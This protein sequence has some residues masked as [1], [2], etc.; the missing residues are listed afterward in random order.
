MYTSGNGFFPF[1]N[2]FTAVSEELQPSSW[3]SGQ[4]EWQVHH[5]TQPWETHDEWQNKKLTKLRTE[6]SNFIKK[7]STVTE[8]SATPP[9]VSNMPLST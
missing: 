2:N 8:S 3:L 7:Q 4:K 6:M 5:H 9:H 1:R